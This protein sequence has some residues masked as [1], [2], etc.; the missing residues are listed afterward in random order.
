MEGKIPVGVFRH[1]KNALEYIER[2]EAKLKEQ[3]IER[4]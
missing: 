3:G 1:D 2:V 4:G